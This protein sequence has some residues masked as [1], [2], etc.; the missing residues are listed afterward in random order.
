MTTTPSSPPNT[1]VKKYSINVLVHKEDPQCDAITKLC[2]ESIGTSKDLAKLPI[3]SLRLCFVDMAIESPEETQLKDYMCMRASNKEKPV[4]VDSN[5]Q[6][7]IDP[8]TQIDGN[9]VF[10]DCNPYPYNM[11]KA[12]RGLTCY[13]NGVMVTNEK[14]NLPLE[15][16]SSKPT[17]SQ[18]FADVAEILKFM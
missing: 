4:L 3:D 8:S 11:S 13:L 14:G 1:E 9:I 10:I 16:I 5:I 6:P 18:M 15:S 17:A 12:N 7:I 2:E